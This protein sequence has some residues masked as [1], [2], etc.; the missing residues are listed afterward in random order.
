MRAAQAPAGHRM[1]GAAHRRGRHG[2]SRAERA[3]KRAFDILVAS[4]ALAL[5]WP[6]IV[7]AWWAAGRAAG[8][9]GLFRQ[10]RIGRGGRPFTILKLRT[11]DGAGRVT[12]KAARPGRLGPLAPQIALRIWARGV[13][14]G[15]LTHV[16]LEDDPT[17]PLLAAI[18]AKQRGT[19]IAANEGGGRHALTIRLGGEDETVFLDAG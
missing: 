7:A 16:W 19:V 13:N 15:L 3:A 1:P 6:L 9:P 12:I 18:P 2:L 4:A 17:C 10:T 11:M 5:L 8:L 14:R